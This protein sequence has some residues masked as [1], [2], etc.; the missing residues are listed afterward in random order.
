[1]SNDV[2]ESNNQL[3]IVG[4][5]GHVGLR[6]LHTK[7]CSQSIHLYRIMYDT[8]ILLD[9]VAIVLLCHGNEP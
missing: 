7:Q 6:Q 2:A 3:L 8:L 5:F 4:H 1:M 9:S